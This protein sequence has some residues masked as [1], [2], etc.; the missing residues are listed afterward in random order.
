MCINENEKELTIILETIYILT[1]N[2]IE[3]K[4]PEVLNMFGG[5]WK[6]KIFENIDSAFTELTKYIN[7][8]LDRG[9]E[10]LTEKEHDE[11]AKYFNAPLSLIQKGYYL[12]SF[13]IGP[14]VHVYTVKTIS[15]RVDQ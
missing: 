10:L 15:V 3:N 6:G 14:I 4:K 7:T 5:I 1:N 9:A 13:K 8:T 12:K 2:K 11:I